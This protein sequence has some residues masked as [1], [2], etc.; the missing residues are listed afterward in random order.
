MLLLTNWGMIKVDGDAGF[1]KNT[2]TVYNGNWL[3]E[4]WWSNFYIRSYCI[5]TYWRISLCHF[6][7]FRIITEMALF[8]MIQNKK[9]NSVI[10]YIDNKS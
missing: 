1:K 7:K 4:I 2:H 3:A 5:I 8:Q 10:M 9:F 6:S